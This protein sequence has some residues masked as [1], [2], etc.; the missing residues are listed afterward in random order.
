MGDNMDNIVINNNNVVNVP[1][2]SRG[3]GTVLMILF[4]WWVLPT[5]WTVLVSLW[6]IWLPIAAIVS[7]FDNSFFARTWYMPWPA[8]LF[9]IR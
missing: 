9:G 1:R 2:G 5:W 8:W 4:F 3:A 7:I 6:L